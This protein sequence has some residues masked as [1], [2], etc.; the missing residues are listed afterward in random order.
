MCYIISLLTLP[1][2]II[3]YWIHKYESDRKVKLLMILEPRQL[4]SIICTV[5]VDM[6]FTCIMKAMQIIITVLDYQSRKKTPLDSM[7]TIK[8]VSV[9]FEL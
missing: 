6:L 1:H 2:V 8:I 3:Y 4:Y 5:K 9:V 7:Q